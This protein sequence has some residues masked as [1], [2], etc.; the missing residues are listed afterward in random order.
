LYEEDKE[1][2]KHPVCF[3][4]NG[5]GVTEGQKARQLTELLGVKITEQQVKE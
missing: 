4:T 2:L 3:L 1:T 5:G